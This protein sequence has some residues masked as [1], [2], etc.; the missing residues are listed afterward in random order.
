MSASILLEERPCLFLQPG[1][2]C[3]NQ[4]AQK[5]KTFAQQD[6]GLDLQLGGRKACQC[7]AIARANGELRGHA[8]GVHRKCVAQR[9]V[10]QQSSQGGYEINFCHRLVSV[11]QVPPP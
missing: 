3:G 8:G 5:L 2:R 10:A 9:P 6:G 4:P 11:L 1:Q 7:R